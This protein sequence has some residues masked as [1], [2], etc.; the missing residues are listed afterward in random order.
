MSRRSY[1]FAALAVLFFATAG[2]SH[3][4]NLV[5]AKIPFDFIASGK[6]MPAGTYVFQDALPN[7]QTEVALRDGNGHGVVVLAT[8][9]E[10]NEP[11]SSILFRKYG[12]S[13][14]LADIFSPSGRLHFGTGHAEKKLI[15]TADAQLIPIA[16]AGD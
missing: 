11:G 10:T 1:S 5:K 15:K 9:L 3:A 2:M 6:T 14:F 13:Y 16:V 8:A 4:Q 7:S 12:E